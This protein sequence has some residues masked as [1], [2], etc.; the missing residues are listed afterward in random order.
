MEQL[1]TLALGATLF[2]V[3]LF[4]AYLTGITREANGDDTS[5]MQ[6]AV[7]TIVTALAAI[8]ALTAI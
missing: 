4:C 7:I 8:V 5:T 6:G 3:S 2:A 1:I